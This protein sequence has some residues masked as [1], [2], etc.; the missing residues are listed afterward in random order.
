MLEPKL[1]YLNL[2]D[3]FAESSVERIIEKIFSLET[4]GI[5]EDSVSDC[6]SDKIDS[7]RSSITLREGCYFVDLP[8]GMKISW[9]K[10]LL[11]HGWR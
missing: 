11:T 2:L 4:M 7:F 10:S 9:Y 5:K 3:Y 8:L 1:K 6:D